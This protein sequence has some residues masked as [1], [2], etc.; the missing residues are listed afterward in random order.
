MLA[1]GRHLEKCNPRVQKIKAS[2]RRPVERL[3]DI[4]IYALFCIIVNIGSICA[5]DETTLN[6]EV[7]ALQS[8]ITNPHEVTLLGTSR[9]A[10]PIH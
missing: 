8:T 2:T 3:C 5:P 7:H 9:L 4:R 10:F 6:A 1:I